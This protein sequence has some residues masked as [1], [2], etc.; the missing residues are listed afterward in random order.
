MQPA[1][2]EKNPA[3]QLNEVVTNPVVRIQN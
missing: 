3:E 2:P 1:Q